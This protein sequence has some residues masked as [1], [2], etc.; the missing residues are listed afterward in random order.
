M[1]K[2]YEE[3]KNADPLLSTGKQNVL[4]HIGLVQRIALH[5]KARLP[6][7]VEIEELVQIGMVGLMEAYHK[8]DEA[9]GG[10]LAA[11]ASKRIKGAIIDEVRKRSPLS[12]NDNNHLRAEEAITSKFLA[13]N[14]RQPT[15]SEIATIMD[16]SVAEYHT[17]RTKS[18]TFM[19]SSFE[20]VSEAG[21]EFEDEQASPEESLSH[22]EHIEILGHRIKTLPERSQLILSLYYEQ[23]LNLKEIAAILGISESRVS[24]LLSKIVSQIRSDI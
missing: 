13:E 10:N 9:E 22:M 1:T 24:Q 3:Y 5:L 8:F 4:D 19:M 14:D 2:G 17:A 6:H 7:F 16:I 21:H 20:E 11:F 23:E 15:S 12:R 18:H